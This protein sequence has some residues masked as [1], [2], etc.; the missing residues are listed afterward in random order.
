MD[1]RRRRT[2]KGDGGGRQM[3]DGGGLCKGEANDVGEGLALYHQGIKVLWFRLVWRSTMDQQ[4]TTTHE[5]PRHWSFF[6]SFFE[7]GARCFFSTVFEEIGPE[8]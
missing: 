1:G 3:T 5:I 7:Y 6:N 2:T 4:R 8:M